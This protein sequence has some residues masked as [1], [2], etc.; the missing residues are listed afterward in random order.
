MQTMKALSRS[1]HITFATAASDPAAVKRALMEVSDDAVVLPSAYPVQRSG[2]F[3]HKVAAGTF[4]AMTGMKT[5]NYTIGQLELSPDRLL[6]HLE[7]RG[8]ECALFEYWH[9]ADLV[10]ALRAKG[11]PCV[12][13]MHNVLWQ[14]RAVE[15]NDLSR[16]MPW[17]GQFQL[18]RYRRHEERIWTYFDGVVAISSGELEYVRSRLPS[19]TRLFYMP[20]GVNVSAWPF[21]RR[22]AEPPRIVYYGGL[23]NYH[24]QEGV[25]R[26]MKHIMPDV[27]TKFPEAELWIVGNNPPPEVKILERNPR[28]HVTGFVQRPQEI[29][30]TMSVALCP[31]LGRFGFRSRI[32][33]LM[34]AGVPVVATPDAV[35]GMG[36]A[37][38]QALLT[39]EVDAELAQHVTTILSN[40]DVGNC[41]SRR[42]RGIVEQDY[43]V[44]ATYESFSREL[45]GWLGERAPLQSNS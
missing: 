44:E 30:A 41:L 20:M 31:F 38:R 14:A 18:N 42:A 10:P 19:S 15:L 28:V 27:W 17:V 6:P 45:F 37:E 32:V 39:G 21:E 16:V 26:C 29:L 4:A 7:G 34:L 9:A 8:F 35:F 3:R 2:R 23:G 12:L 11:V 1:F 22:V 36:L 5:S 25:R 13:D 24:N 40:S 43:S 33:E